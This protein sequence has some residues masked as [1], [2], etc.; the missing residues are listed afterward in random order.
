MVV[1]K[2]GAESSRGG[3]RGKKVAR[4]AGKMEGDAGAETPKLALQ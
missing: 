2:R 4:V 1:A 3:E